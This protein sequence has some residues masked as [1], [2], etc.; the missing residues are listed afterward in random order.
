MR[1][2]K[3]ISELEDIKNEIG[4]APCAI[5]DDDFTPN[6]IEEL[7]IEEYLEDTMDGDVS[8]KFV[9]IEGLTG[10]LQKYENRKDP[11]QWNKWIKE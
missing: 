7:T 6:F 5:S 3:L 11:R 2:S 4:D 9:L 1:I 10:F 8:T